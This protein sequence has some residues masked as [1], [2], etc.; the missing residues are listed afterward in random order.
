[1]KICIYGAGNI[2]CYLGGRL[3]AIG[4][5]V[6]LIVR[7]KIRQQ[8]QQYGLTVSDYL[9]YQN[10]IAADQLQLSDDPQLAAQADIIFV[11]VK[12]AATEQ[13]AHELK[14][15]LTNKTLMISFQNGL[16]NA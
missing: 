3:T 4:C 14:S 7:P 6:E 2:G 9:G 13:V 5:D 11:C 16:A 8:L 10:T 12:S 15:V 1:M